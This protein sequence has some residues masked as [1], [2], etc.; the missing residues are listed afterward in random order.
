MCE[1]NG[2]YQLIQ[3]AVGL[4]RNLLPKDA[5]YLPFPFCHLGCRACSDSVDVDVKSCSL[6]HTYRL[7][8]D[9]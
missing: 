7:G 9:H 4:L 5:A 3:R 1:E 8:F 2:H 6:I